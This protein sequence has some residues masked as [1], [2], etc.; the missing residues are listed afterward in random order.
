[1]NLTSQ[2]DTGQNT[3]V[4]ILYLHRLSLSGIGCDLSAPVFCKDVPNRCTCVVQVEVVQVVRQGQLASLGN[5]ED[6]VTLDQRVG[7]AALVERVSHKL[8][9]APS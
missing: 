2:V 4:N 5:K 6:G 1:M 8:S 3:A 7:L 9:V